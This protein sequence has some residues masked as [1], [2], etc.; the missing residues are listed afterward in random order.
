MRKKLLC[1]LCLLFCCMAG[2]GAHSQALADTPKLDSESACVIDAANGQILYQKHANRELRPASITK[3]MTALL[4]LER[5]E[6]GE[7]SLDDKAEVTRSSLE[8][9]DPN[10]TL[11]GFEVGEKR[12][13][14]DLLYCMLVDSA[15]DAANI[16]AEYVGDGDVDA[17][18]DRMNERAKELGCTHT[19]FA[20]PNGLDPDDEQVHRCSAHDM[21]LISYELTKYPDYFT[22]A[23]AK[24][25]ALETDEVVTEPWE[26]WTK[27]N[28]LL[29]ASE[30]YNKELVGGK[31]GWTSH[32]HHTFVAYMKRGDKML[33]L[34]VMNSI[35]PASKYRDVEKLFDYCIDNYT[36]YTLTPAD[37]SEPLTAALQD[38]GMTDVTV[39]PEA[40]PDLLVT[41]PS[42]LNESAISYTVS[43]DAEMP[44][45][46]LGV[47][48]N[49]WETYRLAT[50]TR[51][52]TAVLASTEIPVKNGLL[53]AAS[54]DEDASAVKDSGP[55]VLL[56][57]LPM[58]DTRSLILTA[59]AAA[60]IL[61]SLLFLIVRLV[62]RKPKKKKEQPRLTVVIKTPPQY[63]QQAE[64]DAEDEKQTTK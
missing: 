20:N 9:L 48:T 59:A 29:P 13:V 39:D 38:A 30:F 41:L 11:V 36:T 44:V 40:L 19:Q 64:R 60:L 21:A 25:Y 50:H 33:V 1:T 8:G 14:R 49:D 31:T 46:T 10:S 42:D 17:F 63:Q 24:N 28:M 61:F 56:D 7:I 18:V 3:Q 27:V 57:I 37:Y 2:L 52:E 58:D 16:L 43:G 45:L 54:S 15:N 6:A 35:D 32:A 34:V 22:Y 53:G 47:Q 12:S 23:G 62:F 51:G 5:I 4:T 26:I 55:K